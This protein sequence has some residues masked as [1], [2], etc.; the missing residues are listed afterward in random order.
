MKKFR[1]NNAPLPF[2]GQK[3]AWVNDQ[4]FVD[5]ILRI[6]EGTVVVDLFGGSG[7]LARRVK[8]LRPDLQV[9][10]NDYD[11]YTERLKKAPRTN[12]LRKQI[13]AI[14]KH[15]KKEERLNEEEKNQI[16]SLLKED[17]DYSTLSSWLLYSMNQAHSK[18]EIK[19]QP[20][21]RKFRLS[22][23][24][25]T[26][27]LDGLIIIKKS[28]EKILQDYEGGKVFYVIDPPYPA[29]NCFSYH[30]DLSSI[31]AINFNLIEKA[32]N[33]EIKGLLFTSEKSGIVQCFPNN[34][35]T[36]K[37]TCPNAKNKNKEIMIVI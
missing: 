25:V 13:Y 37:H 16:I 34:E 1:H 2:Q 12:E 26:D 28:Y 21:Y 30:C 11:G 32:K 19:K 14:A 7:L 5:S 10:Y 33:G 17:D 4:A 18:N 8:D 31:F 15:K 36:V 27:Y 9:V 20:L 29:T 22:D 24:D 3:R 6:R 35:I 23:V